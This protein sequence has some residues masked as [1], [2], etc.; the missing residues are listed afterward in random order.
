MKLPNG[1]PLPLSPGATDR[2]VSPEAPAAPTAKPRQLLDQL[3][4]GNRQAVVARVVELLQR[5]GGQQ[6]LLELRG[7]SLTVD[8]PA[9]L[10]KLQPGDMLSLMRDGNALQL[11]GKLS[12]PAEALLTQALARHLPG[13]HSL[14]SG[15]QQLLTS[16]AQGMRA[17]PGTAPGVTEPLPAAV[18]EAV[19]ALLRIPPGQSALTNLATAA[20]T[21]SGQSGG[22]VPAG[23]APETGV[24]MTVRQWLLNSGLVTEAGLARGTPPDAAD[25]KLALGRVVQSLMHHQGLAPDQFSRFT[26]LT[27]P[28][29]AGAPLQF[30][31]APAPSARPTEAMTVGQTLRLL[32]GMLNR[33]AVNQLHSQLLTTRGGAEGAP[34]INTWVADL[35]WLNHQ[36]EPRLAQ[37]RLEQEWPSEQD[38]AERERQRSKVAEWRFSLVMDLDEAGPVTFEV[39]L[40]DQNLSARVWAE[41]QETV[42]QVNQQLNSLRNSL[43]ELGLEVT[44]LECR[45]GTPAAAVTRLEHRL[46]DI[47]A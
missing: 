18:R 46:V 29:L 1:N 35:P 4:L 23:Q 36:G 14:D 42:R 6:A 24:A 37:L 26:P 2:K 25:L 28:D 9:N 19:Q 16:L 32:A 45:R 47:Q 12:P 5:E 22:T 15:L 13:Q 43:T 8:L 20:G 33:I 30:P 41:R 27:S 3:Q 11:L 40:R 39:A 44:G 38:K 10:P 34:A 31:T 7:Q 17:G 21:R